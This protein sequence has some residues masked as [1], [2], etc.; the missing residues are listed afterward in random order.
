M[1]SLIQLL[2]MLDLMWS[3]IQLLPVLN[4]IWSPIQL[5]PV[6]DLINDIY[7][8]SDCFD[9][10]DLLTP[11]MTFDPDEKKKKHVHRQNALFQL[12]IKVS[13][14]FSSGDKKS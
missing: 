1:W 2:A 14:L 13:T 5:L 9:K 10:F 8:E 4:L 3:P 7:R 12:K 11:L 6:L